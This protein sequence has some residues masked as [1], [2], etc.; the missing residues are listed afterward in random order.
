M[1]IKVII[2]ALILT[3]ILIIAFKSAVPKTIQ[4]NL[5]TGASIVYLIHLIILVSNSKNKNNEKKYR[6]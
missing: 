6:F 3:S 2:S 5:V 1:K 4:Q